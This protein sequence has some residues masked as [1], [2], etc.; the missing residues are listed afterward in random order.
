[1]NNRLIRMRRYNPKSTSGEFDVLFPQAITENILR[2][3]N[4]GVLES[5]LLQ[6]DHHLGDHGVHINRA[7]SD[8]T[9]RALSVRL[10]K[11]VLTDGFPLL[12]TL[13]T[14]L[15]CEPTL[16]FN[17]DEPK[18]IISASGDRIPGG[19]I[20]GSVILLI[21]KESLDKWILL[22][23]DNFTDV[24]KIV[25]PVET[26]YTFKADVDD[27]QIIVI[28]GF[29][30]KSDKLSINYGQTILRAGIDYEFLNTAVNAVRLL[31]FGLDAGE[32]LYFTITSYI[33]T[34]KRGHYRY[35]LK[36]V[37]K[38]VTA[39]E[40]GATVFQIPPEADGA[41]S[42]Q[43]NYEQTILRNNLDY[44][45]NET[46]DTLT[47]KTFALNK[48]EKLVFTITQFVEAPGELVPNNWG[49]TG[50][51]RYSLN[52]VHGSYTATEDHITVFAVPGYNFKRDDI[53]LIQ[54][55]HLFI[56]DVDYT[57]DEIGNVVL[58]KKELMTDE[59]IF[60]TILQGAMMDV[61]N[62]NVIQANG[63]D[64][65]HILL[66]MSY[67]VLCNFYTLL[68]RLKHDMKT[69]PTI[70]C[71]D[72]PAEMVV[73]CFK[74]PILGGYKA[75]SYLW[76]V[77]SE[78]EH[79]WYSLSHSQLDIS[80]VVPQY[81]QASGYANFSSLAEDGTFRETVIPHD[82]GIKPQKIEIT[83]CEPPTVKEDGTITSIGDIWSYAD[84]TNIY[85][86][87]T[88]ES[89]S[90]FHWSA[91]ADDATNDLRTY[92][93]QQITELKSR[94]GNIILH[95]STFDA[96]EDTTSISDIANFH[97]GIDHIVVNFNQTVLR[98][99]IDY[100]V[101]TETNGIDLINN[102]VLNAGDVL[103]FIVLEQVSE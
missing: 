84:E 3:E 47:L 56:L 102:F 22:S 89:I 36:S 92:I 67:S 55:N 25:L 54:D 80:T 46:G 32:I 68:I 49:A 59:E 26:E 96:T 74:S 5:D 70:K 2:S 91:M 77:Y 24:T 87:N 86:G 97:A 29:N 69:A 8:G 85:V 9:A 44:M 31:G 64:G 52:V 33:T 45:I 42:L 14:G 18:Q 94:P 65:Q 57:I 66:D 17:G 53:A 38:V 13:H 72:G 58:L 35:E 98:E 37:D 83:P 51:Y 28:P 79:I 101:N 63:Y 19:Q 50:N 40:D 12:L 34:A 100:V 78:S 93:D 88:G 82:L 62:F 21:W 76:V 27:T 103:Q 23:S 90:K 6:Y 7:L 99:N 73:D 41:H 75:G 1:M 30:R 15:E 48:D 11:A 39:T 4:G 61:P 43:V 60:Y 95:P 20:E 16:S 10:K 71:V 81:K